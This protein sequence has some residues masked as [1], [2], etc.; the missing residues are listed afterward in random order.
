MASAIGMVK[1]ILVRKKLVVRA[2][3]KVVARKGHGWRRPSLAAS[4]LVAAD[5]HAC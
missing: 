1:E 5:I 2:P 4:F 3:H